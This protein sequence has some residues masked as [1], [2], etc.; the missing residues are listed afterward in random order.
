MQSKAHQGHLVQL[1][2]NPLWQ[3][4]EAHLLRLKAQCREA[5][6][7]KDLVSNTIVMAK[8]EL[9]ADL[10]DDINSLFE[11]TKNHEESK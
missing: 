10:I 3:E 8:G 11:S 6:P 5:R 1:K 7:T 4:V 9:I 2:G